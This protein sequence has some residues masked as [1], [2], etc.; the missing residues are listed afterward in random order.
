MQARRPI[1]HSNRRLSPRALAA[2]AEAARRSREAGV[3]PEPR[4]SRPEVPR[5]REASDQPV[6][7]PAIP[8]AVLTSAHTGRAPAPPERFGPPAPE[9]G[10]RRARENAPAWPGRHPDGPTASPAPPAGGIRRTGFPPPT[11][12]ARFAES[13]AVL[14]RRRIRPSGSG[15]RRLRWAIG[16]TFAALVAMVG[17]TVATANHGDPQPGGQATASTGLPGAATSTAPNGSR[18]T[19]AGHGA[20][21]S[22]STS[23]STTLAESV[24]PPALSSLAPATGQAG[25]TVTVTGSN[26]LSPSGQIS[27]Q[28]GSQL[29]PV[30]CS[31][32]TTC[33]VVIPPDP[34][35]T[36]AAPVTI[37]TDSGTSNPLTFTYGDAPD[38]GH[39][40]GFPHQPLHLG[41]GQIGSAS[42]WCGVARCPGLGPGDGTAQIAA[43]LK[44]FEAG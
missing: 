33:T 38:A 13:P 24:G 4:R 22:T 20:A 12:P 8:E 23:T 25:Q 5:R 14:P 42:T 26:F 31:D 34:G 40:R 3:G 32:Q 43:G 37:T 16:I 9:D 35:F 28:V 7:P 18:G 2:I 30:T 11:G 27:A 29:A 10:P 17:A 21:S 15:E 36:P 1:H 6:A 41:R 19:V 44:L 39:S